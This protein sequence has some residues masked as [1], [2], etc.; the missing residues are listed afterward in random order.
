MTAQG[1]GTI[2]FKRLCADLE[3]KR[4]QASP[5]WEKV[6]RRILCLRLPPTMATHDDYQ[7]TF[8]DLLG[9]LMALPLPAQEQASTEWN[10]TQGDIDMA[11]H[12]ARSEFHKHASTHEALEAALSKMVEGL[13]P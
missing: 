13:K 8:D 12:F 11:K 5:P 6:V 1:D 3:Q 7:R 10:V 9:D 4:T 2:I